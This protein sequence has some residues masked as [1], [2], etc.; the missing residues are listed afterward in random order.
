MLIRNI[1]NNDTSVGARH[2]R[3]ESNLTAALH[4]DGYPRSMKAGAE[5]YCTL[6]FI[7]QPAERLDKHSMPV[8]VW[9]SLHSRQ[10]SPSRER[11]DSR[12]H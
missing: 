9:L 3:L 11:L 2:F 5:K 1:S 6:S 7:I 10:S 4:I 8:H 12:Q